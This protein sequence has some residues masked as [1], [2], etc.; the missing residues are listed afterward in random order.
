MPDVWSLLPRPFTALAP[1]EDV[2]DTVFRRLLLDWGA[3]DL[4]FTE[5]ISVRDLAGAPGA[6]KQLYRTWTHPDEARVPLICQIWGTEPAHFEKA[7]R[8]IAALGTFAGIDLNMG[9]PEKKITRKGACAGLITRPELARTLIDA[10]RQGAGSLPVSVKTRLGFHFKMTEDWLG[11]LLEHKPAALT[12]HGRI[13][14][15]MSEGEAE[16]DE[17]AKVRELRRRLQGE[18]GPTVLIGNGDLFSR[19]DLARRKAQVPLDGYMVGRGIFRDPYFFSAG[20]S[21]AEVS[22]AEKL[23]R[24]AQHIRLHREVWQGKRNYEALKRFFKIYTIGFEGA[25]ELREAL[26]LTHDHEA[27]LEVLSRFQPILG[28]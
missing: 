7:A 10:T 12:V 13:A 14:D 19:E 23:A 20:P 2:T 6:P 5:F 25:Q 27:S 18:A 17:I 9:C 3:P 22:P 11:F 28:A 4:W 21:W 16:W 24:M 8:R 1:M 26:M 15:Q